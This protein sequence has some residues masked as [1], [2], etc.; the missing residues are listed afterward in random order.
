M[1]KQLRKISLWSLL[2]AAVTAAPSAAQQSSP[3]AE[4]HPGPQCGGQYECVEDR[5]LSAAEAARSF[6]HPA[7]R[8]LADEQVAALRIGDTSNLAEAL[9]TPAIPPPK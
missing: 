2:L 5:P 7:R 6:A 4:T 9:A 3:A 1:S 8:A